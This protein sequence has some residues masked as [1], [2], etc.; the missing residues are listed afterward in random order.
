MDVEMAILD[1]TTEDEYLL[2]QVGWALRS[3]ADETDEEN[4][5]RAGQAALCSLLL[6]DEVRMYTTSPESAMD[7][8]TALQI[9]GDPESWRRPGSWDNAI[10][11]LATKDG[12]DR[13]Y[14]SRSDRTKPPDT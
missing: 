13:Y 5:I 6:R 11:V 8:Q 14:G 12:A 9:A 10:K 4:A 7:L 2:V 1:L 3:L